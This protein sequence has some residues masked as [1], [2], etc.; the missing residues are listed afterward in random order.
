MKKYEMAGRIRELLGTKAP[1]GLAKLNVEETQ[2]LMELIEN[3]V[4]QDQGS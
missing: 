3:R 1:L 4:N 2:S